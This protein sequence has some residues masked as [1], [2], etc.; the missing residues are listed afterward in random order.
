M[1]QNKVG[2]AFNQVHLYMSDRRAPQNHVYPS[3]QWSSGGHQYPASSSNYSSTSYHSTSIQ[4]SHGLATQLIPTYGGIDLRQDS[5]YQNGYYS[6]NP[7]YAQAG[8]PTV[9]Q[10]AIYASGT[11]GSSAI[12]Q[13]HRSG[14]PQSHSHSHS[15]SHSQAQPYSQAQPQPQYSHSR[16]RSQSQAYPP[17]TAPIMISQLHSSSHY[18]PQ[19]PLSPPL[20]VS[21][22]Y[23]ASPSRPFSCDLCA[24]SFNR[25][26]DLKRHRETHT[27][28]KPYLCNG[29]CGKTF[30][31]KDALKR[32]Q[33]RIHIDY[34]ANFYLLSYSL[35]KGV[36]K[37][38][39]RGPNPYMIP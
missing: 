18:A 13:S 20:S 3:G 32:H 10:H 5:S 2:I 8:S 38:M 33:V 17:P 16:H 22:Q 11:P 35:L 6:S 23:P 29:G 37:W 19:I 1:N 28:E 25:Q 7:A 24:L 12:R 27:G 39:T 9:S 30:T 21:P 36:E 34:H 26:H 31:R 14:Y 15:H 4:E